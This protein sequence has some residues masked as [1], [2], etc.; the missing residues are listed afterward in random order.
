M[1]NLNIEAKPREVSGRKTKH[2]RSENQIPAIVYGFEIEPT[3]IMV[4]EVQ[5]EKLYRLAG[6]S[7]VVKLELAGKGH[8]VLIQDIQR[9][10][11]SGFAIHVDFRRIDMT[12]KVEAKIHI[13][14]MGIPAAVKELGGTLLQSLEEVDVLA[15]PS[16]LVREI[17]VDVTS[18]KTFE[19]KIRLRDVTMPEGIEVLDELD[20]VVASVQAPRSDAELA[21]LEGAVDADV[22]KVEV[23][24]EKKDEPAAVGEAAP[25]EAK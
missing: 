7:T 11:I 1:E 15:L 13:H 17:Q 2:L 19:D 21:A 24:S 6:E 5:M 4:D 14:L 12:K 10:P 16:A 8:D 23:T 18:I 9:D 20:Q 25:A 3:K 22:S